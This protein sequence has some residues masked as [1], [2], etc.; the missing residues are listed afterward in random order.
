M[1]KVFGLFGMIV[2]LQ[3]LPS[4][5]QMRGVVDRGGIN[6]AV[7]WT[8]VVDH[9][10]VNVDW[11]DVQPAQ[12]TYDYSA[13]DAALTDAQLSG[14]KVYLRFFAGIHTPDWIKNNVGWYDY[15]DNGDTLK[16]P[17]WWTDSFGVYY[18][19]IMQRLAARYDNDDRVTTVAISRCMTRYAEPMIRQTNLAE[20]RND[21]INSGYTEAKDIAA[22]KEA[23]DDH[24]ALWVNTFS[25]YAFNP[26]QYVDSNKTA[27]KDITVTLDIMDYCV[28]VLG[29]LAAL[30]N[31]SLRVDPNWSS[32]EI[33]QQMY[34]YMI[35]LNEM[36][37]TVL[38]FQT[39][40][41]TRVGDLPATIQRAIDYKATWL[42][43][44]GG[45]ETYTGSAENPDCELVDF[46]LYDQLLEMNGDQ[47]PSV[48][49]TSPHE[50][51]YLGGI[52]S[53]T[54][55][56]EDDAG[57]KRVVLFVDYVVTLTDYEA[58]YQ[59]DY[60]TAALSDGAHLIK[61]KVVDLAD[62]YTTTTNI[63]VVVDN[64]PPTVSLTSPCDQDTASGTILVE[65][66]ASDANGVKRVVLFVD[67]V[68]TLTDYEAPYQFDYD[69]AALSDGAHLIKVKAVDLVGNYITTTNITVVVD[70]TPPTVSLI[71]PCDQ[72]PVSGTILVKAGASDANGLKR[73]VLFVDNVVTLTDYE[74]PYQFDYDTTA[75]SAG[76][77]L[78]KVKAVDLAGNYTKTDNI[79]VVVD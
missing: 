6:S 77:H 33:Y 10:V 60:D 35:G 12:G 61:V 23:I 11:A 74:A 58:P 79:T 76:S 22:Q 3:A 31:N 49:L 9:F 4:E 14:H 8:D 19:N 59:F 13:I 64:T 30:Q 69:T 7:G 66:G 2:L 71:S 18:R 17:Y 70:N 65:A 73:V 55:D 67:Y 27:K 5:A 78:I 75:L 37:G 47:N 68:V 38:G 25:S 53:I 43:L 21:L 15:T 54:A 56:A 57:I 24:A 42:E 72:D 51:D 45:Y 26:Y 28:V 16:V 1:K 46:D 32:N 29:D 40:T 48:T 41:Y 50:G 36:F 39:A 34:D 20:V 63:T 44:P 62:N 52:V